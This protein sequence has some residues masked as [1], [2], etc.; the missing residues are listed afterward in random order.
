MLFR[1]KRMEQ[2][3]GCAIL[4][5]CHLSSWGF[6]L[7]TFLASTASPGLKSFR[8]LQHRSVSGVSGFYS[9]AQSQEFPAS[10]ASLS[11]KPFRLSGF[12]RPC[13]PPALQSICSGA[14][15]L[16]GISQR[17]RP[18]TGQYTSPPHRTRRPSADRP[19][20]AFSALPGESAHP[21]HTPQSGTD[22]WRPTG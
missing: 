15:P 21:S 14:F 13:A 10:T 20:P 11:L 19:E 16:L 5:L 17:L 22:R 1:S 6:R 8:L 9:I 12:P 18:F 3:T 7:L 4:L 2:P